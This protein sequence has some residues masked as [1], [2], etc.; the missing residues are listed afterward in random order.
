[1]IYIYPYKAGL[2]SVRELRQ[3][4]G[5][6]A[7]KLQGSRFRPG[8]DKTVIN[9]GSSTMP[10][11][12]MTCNLLNPP[13]WVGRVTNKLHFFTDMEDAGVSTPEWTDD[14]TDAEDWLRQGHTVMC[15]TRLQGHSGQGIVVTS[16]GQVL[17]P[18]P[19]YTR[20]VKTTSEWRVH[21]FNGAVICVQRKV[22]RRDVPDDE[23]NW[24]VRSH[25]NGFVFQR[26]NIEEP[27]GLREMATHAVDAADLD[28]GAVDIIYN[29]HYQQHYVLEINTAPNLEGSTVG[30]YARAITEL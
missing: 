13:S 21:V 16:P 7:I 18:A 3:H 30:D 22:R 20:Y 4:P 27:D 19:L 26:N 6:R 9:W 25:A 14:I 28:F 15:R 12:L 29:R 5:I 23:V 1:M 8:P 11:H 24:A 10:D 2:R 17:T